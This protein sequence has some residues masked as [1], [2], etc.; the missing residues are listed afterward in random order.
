MNQQVLFIQG[1]GD[2]GY[3]ADKALV[4]SL[5]ENLGIEYDIKYPE[6]KSE[7]SKPDFGWTKQIE[8]KISDTKNDVFIVGHSF[9]AS[10]ILKYLFE[11]SVN[12]NI[13]SIFLIA[14]PFW[15][16]NEDWEIGLKLQGNFAD[17]LPNE[18]PIFFYPCQDD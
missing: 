6:I 17:K 16:G 2:G 13:K 5:Q 15:S 9:G 11:N 1:G 10:M 12:K 18:V 8:R 4:K 3:E 7:E 14:T